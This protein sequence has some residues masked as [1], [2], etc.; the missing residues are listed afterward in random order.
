MVLLKLQKMDVALDD[1]YNT[2]FESLSGFEDFFNAI[3]GVSPKLGKAQ[4]IIDLC[5]LETPLGTMF[6]CAT[7]E[8]ICLLEFTDRKMLETAFKTLARQLNT[9]ILPGENAH[10]EQLR[11]QLNEY[12][13]G[14]RRDFSLQL[15]T[16]GTAFQNEVWNCLKT[17]P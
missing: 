2:G 12:F 3:F 9:R 5:R 1:I 8:G 7:T 15:F 10:F 17:I 6:A 13:E 11:V 16:P 14:K 4:R